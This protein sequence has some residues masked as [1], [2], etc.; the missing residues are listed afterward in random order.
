MTL[1][2]TAFVGDIHGNLAALNGLAEILL[3]DPTVGTVVFLGDYI[4]KGLN[5]AG[6]VARLIELVEA[7]TVVALRGNHEEEMLAALNHGDL[8]TFLKKGGANTI[9]SYLCGPASPDVLNDFRNAVPP[10]H[11][12]FLSAMPAIYETAEIRASHRP[13]STE[14]ARFQVS[15]HVPVGDLPAIDQKSAQLDTNCGSA[16]GRLSAFFWPARNYVQVDSDGNLVQS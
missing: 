1:K 6:V 7:G 9:R 3:G 5:P 14:T 11:V 12:E 13:V 15:A 16:T 4:N 8:A 2:Q 10:E